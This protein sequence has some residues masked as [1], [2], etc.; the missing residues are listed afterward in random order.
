MSIPNKQVGIYKITSPSGKVYIGQSWDVKKRFSKYRSLQS[1]KKQRILYNS[2]NKYGWDNHIFEI[3]E[4]F[5]NITQQELDQKEIEYI[6]FYKEKGYKLLNIREG[7]LGGKLP[8]DSIDKMLKT[9][10]KWN[11]SEETKRIISEKHKGMKHSPETIAKLKGRKLSKQHIEKL[12]NNKRSI[13]TIEKFKK[14]ILPG[15]L[16]LHTELGIFYDSIAFAARI[17]NI[18]QKTLHNKLSGISKNNTNLILV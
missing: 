9:R 8:K 13:E 14:L 3:L 11:H 16:V 10:G 7:G 2:F 12:K 1:I 4:E 15:K 17:F 5:I 6:S 18:N